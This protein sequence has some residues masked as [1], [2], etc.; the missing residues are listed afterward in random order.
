MLVGQTLYGICSSRLWKRGLFIYAKSQPNLRTFMAK[1][2]SMVWWTN[3]SSIGSWAEKEND[4]IVSDRRWILI[5]NNSTRASRWCFCSCS[6]NH[7]FG[8]NHASEIKGQMCCWRLWDP[9]HPLF[10]PCLY[11]TNLLLFFTFTWWIYTYK[12]R[13]SFLLENIKF[14]SKIEKSICASIS[15]ATSGNKSRHFLI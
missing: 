4:D 9:L 3:S 12:I 1:F 7:L 10:S 5:I 11:W 13:Y 15:L 2:V 14:Y 6:S 8:Q